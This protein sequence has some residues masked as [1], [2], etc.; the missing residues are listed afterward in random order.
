MHVAWY[1]SPD[2]GV[3]NVSE[4]FD[5]IRSLTAAVLPSDGQLTGPGYHSAG[6]D[7]KLVR[8]FHAGRAGRKTEAL[9]KCEIKRVV[10][11]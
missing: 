5:A 7:L 11:P 1:K 3:P 8:D 2:R 9:K 4:A 6:P 10:N